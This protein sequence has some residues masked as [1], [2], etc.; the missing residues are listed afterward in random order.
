MSAP[1]VAVTPDGK[2]FAA[3]W[4]DVRE[5]SPRVWW[6]LADTPSFAKEAS[7]SDAADVAC[8]HPSLAV[9]A[10]GVF[11]AAWEEGQ[12]ADARICVRTS[13]ADGAAREISERGDGPPGYP[14]MAVGADLVVAAWEMTV[15]GAP[16]RVWF[17]VLED[18]RR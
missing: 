8:D 9:D 3:A 16:A 10:R 17:R 7:I 4:K 1:A 14:V 15:P 2:R 18:T 13:A 11:W 6:A 12:G 5:G